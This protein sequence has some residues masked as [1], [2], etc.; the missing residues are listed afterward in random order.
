MW[1][2]ILTAAGAGC[3]LYACIELARLIIIY[4]RNVAWVSGFG[5]EL[6]M[7]AVAIIWIIFATIDILYLKRDFLGGD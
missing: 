4:W 1:R 5:I 3:G 6:V 7:L 2:K